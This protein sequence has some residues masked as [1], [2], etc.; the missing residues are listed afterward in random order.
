MAVAGVLAGVLTAA[1][2]LF[3]WFR[4]LDADAGP[5]LPA[6][7][8]PDSAS[9]SDGGPFVGALRRQVRARLTT[10][11]VPLEPLRGPL[12]FRARNVIW[13][14]PGTTRD[15]VRADG[16]TG[17]VDMTAAN[18]GD[19]VLGEVALER[20][21]VQLRSDGR[22]WNYER[23][24]AGVLAGPRGGTN[25]R[26]ARTFR[27]AVLRVAAGSVAVDMPRGD[28]NLNAVNAR[29][30]DVAFSGPGVAAPRLHVETL[31]STITRPGTDQELALTARAGDFSFPERTT[32]FAIAEAT[33]G[34]TRIEPIE[35]V[36]D[37]GAPGYGITARGRAVEVAFT[38]LQFLMPDRIP[39]EGTASATFAVRPAA[40]DGTAVVLTDLVATSGESRVAG[41]VSAQVYPER[42]IVDEI[43]LRLEPMQLALLEPFTG[44][45]PYAG[46]LTGTL[47]GPGSD[48]QVDVVASVTA[49]GVPEPFTTRLA[50]GVALGAEGLVLRD[51]RAELRQVPLAALRAYA[52]GLPLQGS[53]SGTVVLNGSPR[54]TPLQLDTRLELGTGLATLA[55]TLDLTGT[56]PRY[57]ITGRLIAIDLQSVFAAAVPP[58]T[59][60]ARYT[61]VG[62]GFD[63]ATLDARVRID[64]GFSGWDA[65]PGDTIVVAAA[66]RGGTAEIADFSARLAGAALDAEG[67][68]RFVEPISGAVEYRLAVNSLAPY[69]PYI[70]VIGDSIAGGRLDARGTV[71]GP[72]DRLQVAGSLQGDGLEVG[73]WRAA[74][75]EAQ[76]QLAFTGVLPEAIVTLSGSDIATPT[77]GSYRTLAADVR[78]VAPDFELEVSA[79]HVNGGEVE[80][81]AEGIIPREGARSLILQRAFFD[82]TEGRWELQAPARFAWGGEDGLRVSGFE[83]RHPESAGMIALDGRILPLADL[84]A[85]AQV[86][87][88][89]VGQVLDLLGRER[90]VTGRLWLDATI[91]PPGSA[92]IIDG[93]FRLDS[94]VVQGVRMSQL[95]GSL[96]FA[97]GIA[98]TELLAV[99]DSA[100]GRLDVRGT[101]PLR[102]A[103]AP[104][105]DFGISETGPLDA[106]LQADRVSLVLLRPFAPRIRDLQG[107]ID[108]T[109]RLGG[110]ADAPSLDGRLALASGR[111]V[112]PELNQTFDSI[113]GQLVF[114]GRRAVLQALRLQSEGWTTLSGSMTFEALDR[115]VLDMVAELDGFAVFGVERHPDGEFSGRVTL[116]G[117]LDALVLSGNVVIDDGYVTIPA[118]SPTVEFDFDEVAA[119]PALGTDLGTS[120][121]GIMA[122]MRIA[123]L[124]VRMGEAAWIEGSFGAQEASAQLAGTLT[125]NRAGD[126]FRVIGTLGGER[127]TYTLVAGPIVR[128]FEIIASEVRFLGS[129]PPNPAIDITARRVVL[130][131]TGQRVE[132]EVN[133]TGTARTPRLALASADAPNIPESELLSFLLF[134]RPS[135]ALGESA[136][137]TGEAVFE[138]TYLGA[139][140]EV[141]GMELERALSADLGLQLDLFQVR[142]GQGIGGLS[143]PSFVVGRQL[144]DDVFL[145]LE[146][147]ISAL[148]GEEAPVAD[149]WAIR[150][151]WAFDRRS[152]LEGGLEPANRGRLLRG[153][154][155]ALPVAQP[156]QQLFLELRRRWV[157]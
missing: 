146:T 48:I 86:A 88:L 124:Q 148:F 126:D 40:D 90:T 38:D 32:E 69:G 153:L 25:G 16:V 66:V 140:G 15:F 67:R 2:V 45:L 49:D 98:R 5:Q 43:D 144:A 147:G 60:T 39:D 128:R 156:K 28:F 6:A 35:G 79:S 152:S 26:P 122:N 130:D 64:G 149:T 31:T 50:G 155:S 59:L 34:A 133:I 103:L 110:S 20:P 55:G 114:E 87:N 73:D 85:R 119:A 135:F 11:A 134:G 115:P 19:I 7:M 27:I 56:V 117:E 17:T 76:Y 14:E 70:P 132:V 105:I 118:M 9:A 37:P 139:L 92:P 107:V 106:I 42:F 108:G 1:L 94:A 151:E 3:L 30:T 84:D 116:E 137:G 125:V 142:F 81:A 157:Y 127:G 36:W 95:E 57:D 10:R 89:P 72:I 77:A 21:R 80:V 75:L 61:A 154:G 82:L 33:I 44:E 58:V 96:D 120:T 41:S 18:R 54:S 101:L 68:W 145:T 12:S 136:V 93:T 121:G 71:S 138:Q 100:A 4:G 52:P 74:A 83:L 150:L 143:Q 62:T 63:P 23:P 97:N 65:Q 123:D 24:L 99:F 111:L 102:I 109:V 53:I 129:T 141:L 91:R 8:R 112:V 104:E 13:R 22:G 51:L 46:T 47:R 29:L 113:G 78:L 131:Q